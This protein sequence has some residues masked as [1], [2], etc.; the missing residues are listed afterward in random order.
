MKILINFM[1]IA[2][3]TTSCYHTNKIR[4]N[5]R[6]ISQERAIDGFK[7]ISVDGD[8]DI[9]VYYDTL[10]SLLVEAESNLLPYIITEVRG[11]DHLVI[12]TP[13]MFMVKN[14]KKKHLVIRMPKLTGVSVNGSGNIVC[15]Y[16]KSEKCKINI[17]GSGNVVANL[18]A[19]FIDATINGSGDILLSGF[20]E[21]ANYKVSGSG[22]IK[23]FDMFVNTC[24]ANIIGSGD[25]FTFVNANLNVNISGS[26]NLKYLGNPL[27]REHIS[28]SGSVKRK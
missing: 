26:G 4:G 27:I 7:S 23:A 8:F 2:L 25:I 18:D 10:F 12:K 1:L 6:I 28:G 14:T 21:Y 11:G 24:D 5:G 15:E 13:P 17:N 3:I 20:S 22:T 16:F 19:E 9:E